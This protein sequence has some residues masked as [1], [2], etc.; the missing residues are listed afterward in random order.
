[1]VTVHGRT[2]SQMFSGS[3]NWSA[4]K[5]VKNAIKIPV[6]VNGDIKSYQDSVLAIQESGADGVMIGRG[7]YGRPWLISDIIKGWEGMAHEELS[8]TERMERVVHDVVEHCDMIVNCYGES[9]GL[10]IFRKHIGWYISG[11]ANASEIRRLAHKAETFNELKDIVLPRLLPLECKSEKI[12][13][14]QKGCS[15]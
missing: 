7:S 2:R 5:L 9:N 1:M 12:Q 4:V 14:F 8:A 3:A 15:N 13:I 6:I 11:V 10:N